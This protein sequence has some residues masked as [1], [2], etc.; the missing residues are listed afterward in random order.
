[1]LLNIFLIII[2]LALVFIGGFGSMSIFIIIVG[3]ASIA[4]GVRG[5]YYRTKPGETM[6][7]TLRIR[8]DKLHAIKEIQQSV[9]KAKVL[10]TLVT[11]STAVQAYYNEV[12]LGRIDYEY[13]PDLLKFVKKRRIKIVELDMTTYDCTGYGEI[14]FPVHIET[15]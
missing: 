10:I 8:E 12:Y 2:G 14:I 4:L 5:F 13:C 9:N 15:K 6:E 1:M 11:E 7:V 3:V